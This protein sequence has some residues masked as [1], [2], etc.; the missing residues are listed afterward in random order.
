MRIL[1]VLLAIAC[2]PSSAAWALEVTSIAPVAAP[3][4]RRVTLTGGPFSADIQLFL[5]S[6]RL[7]P[8]AVEEKR[9]FFDVPELPEGEYALVLRE[10]SG[11][12]TPATTFRVLELLPRIEALSPTTLDACSLQQ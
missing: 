2:L 5:G 8:A 6:S 3:P 1:F 10:P 4:E 12:R 7:T 9:L 11:A